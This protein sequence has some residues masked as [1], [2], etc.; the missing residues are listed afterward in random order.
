MTL[1]T[2]YRHCMAHDD[3][4]DASL[5]RIGSDYEANRAFSR[6]VVALRRYQ[7]RQEMRPRDKEALELG[8]HY[9]QTVRNV[10]V[11]GANWDKQSVMAISKEE[12]PDLR[13]ED[14]KILVPDIPSRARLIE[15]M[16]QMDTDLAQVQDSK[17]SPETA[18]HFED[19]FSQLS[20]WTLEEV[21]RLSGHHEREADRSSLTR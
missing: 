10:L 3:A 8:R 1:A 17:A 21:Q 7:R 13:S 2:G 15:A 20:A 14:S 9:L 4:D 16:E 18:K 6:L 5:D 19:T 12:L 11:H